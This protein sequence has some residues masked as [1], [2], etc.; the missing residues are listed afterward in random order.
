MSIG[1]DKMADSSGQ[2]LKYRTLW[3]NVTN[4]YFSDDIA[5]MKPRL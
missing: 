2:S 5:L 1:K 3:E 4:I